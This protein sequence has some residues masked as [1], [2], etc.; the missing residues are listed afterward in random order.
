MEHS[1]SHDEAYLDALK[2]E[3]YFDVVTGF[4]KLRDI[5]PIMSGAQDY[6]SLRRQTLA[7]IQHWK[8]WIQYKLK[9]GILMVNGNAI[10]VEQV[11]EQFAARDYVCDSTIAFAVYLSLLLQKPLLIE[12]EPGVGKTEIAKVLS[13]MV[14]TELIRLQCYEGLDENRALYEWNYQKQL[15][16]IQGKERTAEDVFSEE[17]LM[18]RP[19]MKAILSETSPV[20]LIDEIDKAD[21]EFEAFL[22]EILSDFQISIPEFGTL[23]AK[24]IPHI[25]ITNNDVREL[26]DALKRRCIYLYIDYPT[27]E[28]EQNILVKKVPGIKAPLAQ[29]IA[30][31]M[32]T[33]R[34][35]VDLLKK[36]SIA[37]GIDFA[38]AMTM[39]GIQAVDGDA[40]DKFLPTL[41]KNKEDVAMMSK[42]GGGKWLAEI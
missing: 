11:I 32:H 6:L 27:V 33:L 17:F 23:K 21:E 13:S 24:T 26:T 3:V 1:S 8:Y 15:L 18:V 5:D 25:I 36:P 10:T 19:L 22:L 30:E 16:F 28:K 31:L 20:L 9:R 14:N 29:Q 34:T 40:I 38:R 42:R 35:R 39:E 4:L 37:E 2:R 12:G 7:R 41:L